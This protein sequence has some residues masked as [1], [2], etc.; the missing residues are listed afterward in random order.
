MDAKVMLLPNIINNSTSSD[1]PNF[2]SQPITSVKVANPK[3]LYISISD[4]ME[5]R[6]PD[7]YVPH[8]TWL[9]RQSKN[10]WSLVLF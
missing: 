3:K 9:T 10:K 6:S 5:A 7:E 1:S 2:I 4:P 8:T